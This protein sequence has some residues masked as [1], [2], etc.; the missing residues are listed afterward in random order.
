MLDSDDKYK[1][2][3]IVVNNKGTNKYKTLKELCSKLNI[4][5]NEVIFL[6]DSTNDL[7]IISKVG[8]GIAMGNAL[9]EVKEKAKEI[10]L[11]NDEDGIAVFLEKLLK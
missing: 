8:M 7:S 11:S 10:T 3:W 1:K 5:V 4:L 2:K 9:Q 6:G